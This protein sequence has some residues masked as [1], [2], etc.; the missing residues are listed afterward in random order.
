MSE[1]FVIRDEMGDVD[2]AVV[3]LHQHILSYLVAR[4]DQPC[5]LAFKKSRTGI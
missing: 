3:L 5:V 4:I 2:V 1:L